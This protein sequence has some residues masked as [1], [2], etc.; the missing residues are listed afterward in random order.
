MFAALY[1]V[2]G[3]TAFDRALR[4]HFQ[5]TKVRGTTTDDLVEAFVAVDGSSARHIFDD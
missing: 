1:H 2:L 4:R 3:E 5:S